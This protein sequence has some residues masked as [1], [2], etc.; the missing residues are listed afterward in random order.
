[1]EE[2]IEQKRIE[3]T[4]WKNFSLLFIG[5]IVSQFGDVAYNFAIA[6]YV[7]DITKGAFLPALYVVVSMGT[8]FLFMLF[9]GAIADRINKVRVMY[10]TDFLRG[11]VMCGGYLAIQLIPNNMS[12]YYALIGIALLISLLGS[13][14]GPASLALIPL[15]VQQD[16]LQ[17][18]NSYMSMKNSLLM[19]LGLAIGGIM[20][21]YLGV[22]LIFIVNGISY[23]LSGISEMFI[24]IEGYT[25]IVKT[26]I[27][28][29]IKH[30]F[31]DLK[32]GYLYLIKDKPLLCIAIFALFVNFAFAP[33]FLTIIPYLLREILD[34]NATTISG[35]EISL[36][37]GVF[38]MGFILSVRAQFEK[39][40]KPLKLGIS[41]WIVFNFI[42]I[43][44]S[45]LVVHSQL[46][47]VAFY[48]GT[49]LI[50]F[51]CGLLNGLINTPINVVFQKRVEPNY[52]GRVGTMFSVTAM[53]AQPISIFIAGIIVSR[54]EAVVDT[55]GM[56]LV[57]MM[58]ISMIFGAI[59][60][61]FMFINKSIREI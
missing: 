28:E 30:I 61:I 56:G 50:I 5:S 6:I 33:L 38:V 39:I 29:A 13:L 11:L 44:L 24:H 22:G 12:Q 45:Y 14:F 18:A 55:A 2:K 46:T 59:V 40:N 37:V 19:I 43:V 58:F 17:K 10:I 1:M 20:Y 42:L 34:M 9:G 35:V 49:L 48:I 15:V 21:D 60:M 3:K 23:I 26:K 27:K 51:I 36:S 25:N 7:M 57:Y 16:D 32:E 53:A 54:F 41:I 4:N 8:Y 47:I 31:T 52:L